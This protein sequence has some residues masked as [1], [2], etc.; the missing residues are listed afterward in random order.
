MPVPPGRGAPRCIL[1][2]GSRP[3]GPRDRA[4]L[5]PTSLALSSTAFAP[6]RRG[7]TKSRRPKSADSIP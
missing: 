3:P 4:E 7:P 5:L 6:R 2:R 1:A